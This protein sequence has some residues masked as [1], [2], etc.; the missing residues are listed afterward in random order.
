MRRLSF[1]FRDVFCY[2]SPCP[3]F[4]EP[5]ISPREIVTLSRKQIK[6]LLLKVSTVICIF[7]QK[8]QDKQRFCKTFPS[9]CSWERL[10]M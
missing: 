5:D 8:H 2:L 9:I 1:L 7:H 6:I 10:L 3:P 4:L